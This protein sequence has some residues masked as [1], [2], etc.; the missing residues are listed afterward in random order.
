M[1]VFNNNTDSHNQRWEENSALCSIEFDYDGIDMNPLFK[2]DFG[3]C[4]KNAINSYMTKKLFQMLLVFNSLSDEERKVLIAVMIDR[5]SFRQIQK[6]EIVKRD[7]NTI[8][9]RYQSAIQK[10]KNSPLVSIEFDS[11]SGN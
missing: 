1:S 5:K 10:I 3:I 8:Q 2:G 7:K 6:E 11:K 9:E 4:L